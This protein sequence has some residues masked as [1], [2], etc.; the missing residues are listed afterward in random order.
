MGLILD[1]VY[2]IPSIH[3]YIYVYIYKHLHVP[4]K[5]TIHVGRQASPMDG[6]GIVHCI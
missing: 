1:I 4:Y 3:I 6:M 2:P 5:S